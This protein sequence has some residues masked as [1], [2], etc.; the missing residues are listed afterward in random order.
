MPTDFLSVLREFQD[1]N[2]RYVLVGGLAVLLHG[3]DRLTADIDLIVD[4]APE[5]A[6]Q[7]VETLLELGFKANAPVDPRQFADRAIRKRWREESGMV[8][9][10][11]WDPQNRRPTVDLFA[12][13]PMDFEELVSDSVLV[14]LASATVRVAS[15]NH[16]IAIKRAAGRPKDLD[17]VA[18]LRRLLE[19]NES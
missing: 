10:S 2:I 12:D 18:R 5:R 9:L 13:H 19:K 3:I 8:V 17:D 15:V 7:V 1:R 6:T 4:L 14:R 11:F 16:L